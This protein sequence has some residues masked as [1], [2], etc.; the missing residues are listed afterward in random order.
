MNIRYRVELDDAENAQLYKN[1]WCIQQVNDTYVTRMED[2]LDLY[3]EGADPKRRVVYFD[4]SPTQLIGE[5]RQLIP[6]PVK[7]G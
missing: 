6:I 1:M 5:V 7:L 4:E 3:T 2:V